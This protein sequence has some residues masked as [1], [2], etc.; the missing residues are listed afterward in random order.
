MKSL[1][2]ITIVV[3]VSGIFLYY[4]IKELIKTYKNRPYDPEQQEKL[5]K[6]DRL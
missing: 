1:V 6:G 2:I 3:I 5:R 4:I